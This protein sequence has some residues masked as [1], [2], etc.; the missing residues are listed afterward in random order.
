[1][2]DSKR[3]QVGML[4]MGTGWQDGEGEILRYSN[5]PGEAWVLDKMC[6]WL[7]GG[8]ADKGTMWSL[9][10]NDSKRD[11]TAVTARI[12]SLKERESFPKWLEGRKNDLSSFF[13]PSIT[14]SRLVYWLYSIKHF[15]AKLLSN[16]LKFDPRRALSFWS[17]PEQRIN[18]LVSEQTILHRSQQALLTPPPL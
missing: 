3:L 11:W 16:L 15:V 18:I 14:Q 17:F 7:R 5:R 6:L 1:M 10:N 2:R 8:E 13:D 9:G 4:G 12:N